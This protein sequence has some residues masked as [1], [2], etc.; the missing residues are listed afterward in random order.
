MPPTMSN[1]PI[2]CHPASLPST[3]TDYRKAERWMSRAEAGATLCISPTTV[4]KSTPLTAMARVSPNCRPRPSWHLHVE[5]K[6]VD[7]ERTTD[8]RPEFPANTYDAIIVCF[9]LHRR[10]FPG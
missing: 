5:T 10:Y 1:S 2:P 6:Q 9:Y 8:E 3:C 4:S 7:L